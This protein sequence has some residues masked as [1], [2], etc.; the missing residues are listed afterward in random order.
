MIGQGLTSRQI[1]KKLG[2]S[3]QTVGAHRKHIAEKLGTV[4]SELSQAAS[5]RYWNTK[6]QQ[7]TLLEIGRQHSLI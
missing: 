5:A 6:A 2:I 7:E 4:G 3:I 1:S